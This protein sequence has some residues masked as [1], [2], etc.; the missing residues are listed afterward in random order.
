[1]LSGMMAVWY[2]LL[3]FNTGH[4][5]YF[6]QLTRVHLACRIVDWTGLVLQMISIVLVDIAEN[7]VK[8]SHIR[9]KYQHRYLKYRQHHLNQFL[10][11]SI[12]TVDTTIYLLE[13][14]SQA[15]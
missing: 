11:I 10:L 1:M 4:L 3:L 6:I 9:R 5:R 13:I 2:Y 7:V 14:G 8:M 15:G 12:R